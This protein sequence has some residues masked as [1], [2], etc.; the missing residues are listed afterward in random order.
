MEVPPQL[1]CEGESLDCPG[2]IGERD[3]PQQ[4]VFTEANGLE[5]CLLFGVELDDLI[6]PEG[7]LNLR[8]LVE[9]PEEGQLVH[10][11]LVYLRP[12]I[13]Q[14]VILAGKLHLQ[15]LVLLEQ[16]LYDLILL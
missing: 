6:E 2:I 7:L 5:Q 11:H 15:V 8:K 9:D 4:V 1:A 10:L 12:H 16:V 3:R 13:G 14:H